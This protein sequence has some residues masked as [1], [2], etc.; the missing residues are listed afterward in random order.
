MAV[1]GVADLLPSW[2]N[3][4]VPVP[5]EPRIDQRFLRVLFRSRLPELS[6]RKLAMPAGTRRSDPQCALLPPP[7]R[8]RDRAFHH[9]RNPQPRRAR[10]PRR[11]VWGPS[12]LVLIRAN[13]AS[14]ESADTCPASYASIR[15]S[16]SAFHASAT[17]LSSG[18]SKLRSNS[19]ISSARSIGDRPSA[20]ERIRLALAA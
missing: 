2:Q 9:C 10:V 13:T 15:D 3:Q 16:A 18:G 14:A 8:S 4:H 11:T 19:S 5:R 20:S 12:P 1:Q 7:T 17:A 6:E